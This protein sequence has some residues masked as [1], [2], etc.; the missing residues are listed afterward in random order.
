MMDK[1]F[2]VCVSCK[3]KLPTTLEFFNKKSSSNDNLQ[4]V[5]KSCNTKSSKK[6]YENNKEKIKQRTRDRVRRIKP[7]AQQIVLRALKKGCVDCGE[8]DIIVLEF[9]H[10]GDKKYEISRMVN[11]A[12][13][14]DKLEEEISKCVIRCANCHRRKTAKDYNWWKLDITNNMI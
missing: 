5:C 6:H 9:D 14:L 13:S 7:L 1:E 3:D 11:E 4:N 8:K 2:K 10:Q 12:L